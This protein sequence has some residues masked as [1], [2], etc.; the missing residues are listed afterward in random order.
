[1]GTVRD[2]AKKYE[3]PKTLNIA[4]LQKVSTEAD[5]EHKTVN[6]GTP[7][8]F[9]Y[10]YIVVSGQE[11]RVPKTVI[12][13]LKQHLSVKPSAVAFKVLKDGTGMNTEYTV[14]LL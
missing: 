3:S 13:Q 14:V 12:K 11:Y 10:D 2:A 8:E 5:I 1:M 6:K 9:S 4:D 7:E